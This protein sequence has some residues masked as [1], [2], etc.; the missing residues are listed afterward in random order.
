MHGEVLMKKHPKKKSNRISALFLLPIAAVVIALPIFL[1]ILVEAPIGDTKPRTETVPAADGG[2]LADDLA[3]IDGSHG[4]SPSGEVPDFSGSSIAGADGADSITPSA[5][6]EEELAN[7]LEQT[8][9][10]SDVPAYSGALYAVINDNIPFFPKTTEAVESFER[11][12]ELDSL[13]RCGTACASIGQDIMPTEARGEIGQIRPSGWHT[14]KYDGIDGNYLYNRC[15]LIAYQLSG[16]NANER[17][18]ITGTRNFNAVGMLPFEEMAGNYVRATGH[19]VLYRVTPMFRGNNLV[20]DGVLMEAWSVEDSGAGICFNVFVYNVQPGIVIDYATGSSYADSD[21]RPA[22]EPAAQST[23]SE[24]SA[25]QNADAEEVS[26]LNP[27]NNDNSANYILNTNTL[28]FHYPDCSSVQEMSER[29]KL[30][31]SGT[32]DEVIAMG[33]VPCKRCNP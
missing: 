23:D 20:A 18:L 9:S 3:G 2:V 30:P 13:G 1:T 11:Y 16:E 10:L 22:E 21:V 6:F 7:G 4:E 15:H 27:N 28:K 25:A 17:N 14:V 26:P 31:Y 19:H 8:F 29:N 24:G 5:F 32:R 33:Y 12:A